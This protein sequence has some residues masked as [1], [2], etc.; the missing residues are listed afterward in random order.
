[1][2]LRLRKQEVRRVFLAFLIA[3]VLA[4][5][6]VLQAYSR[7]G[8]QTDPFPWPKLFAWELTGWYL[9]LIFLIPIQMLARR[10]PAGAVSWKLLAAIHLPL[11]FLFSIF[12]LLIQMTIS[13]KIESQNSLIHDLLNE[14]W[15][16]IYYLS[17]RMLIYMGILVVCHAVEYRTRFGNEELKSSRLESLLKQTKLEKIKKQLNPQFLYETLDFIVKLIHENSAR[18]ERAIARL[19]TFLRFSLQNSGALVVP[20]KQELEFVKTYLDLENSVKERNLSLKIGCASPLNERLVPVLILFH[21][22]QIFIDCFSSVGNPKSHD[23]SIQ[24]HAKHADEKLHFEISFLPDSSA[25]SPDAYHRVFKTIGTTLQEFYDMKAT[26]DFQSGCVMLTFSV[27]CDEAE[28][29]RIQEKDVESCF[30]YF[31]LK[32]QPKKKATSSVWNWAWIPVFWTL[33]G[34]YFAG[35]E[36]HNL[37]NP[38]SWTNQMIQAIPWACWA[39]V[40]PLILRTAQRYPVERKWLLQSLVV[41][42]S[43]NSAIWFTISAIGLFATWI[44]APTGSYSEYLFQNISKSRFAFSFFVYWIM[45]AAGAAIDHYRRYRSEELNTIR[46]QSGLFQAQIDVLRMQLH[47]HFLFNAL[48]SISQLLHENVKAAEEMLLRLKEFLKLTLENTSIH[49]TTL[50]DELEYMKCYLEIQHMRF[51]DKLH[52][53]MNI[54]PQTMNNLVPH[55]LWQ[56]VIENAIRHGISRMNGPGVIE[57]VCKRN[58]DRLLLEV[59][60]NGPGLPQMPAVRQG[61]GLT[62]I[63][64]ILDS[65]YGS[66]H[67]FTIHNAP[68]GGMIASLLIPAIAPPEHEL[69]AQSKS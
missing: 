26:S 67:E 21:P 4:F 14:H 53:K 51:Q 52:V 8:A 41:H 28:S 22:V 5:V 65:L 6:F 25:L 36:A 68:E 69:I 54:E 60:D 66:S 9:W 56:P 12:H 18:A 62:T 37:A 10:F 39:A 15:F 3:T 1:M 57:I 31:E 42:F 46:L 40:T 55:L 16:C 20:L 44:T 59:R 35:R 43:L 47:P 64:A 17:W 49:E 29:Q 13:W 7:F 45:V 24:I 30:R 38:S 61:V 19:G 58:E 2:N 33:M 27:R 48:N 50:K 11:S 32:E 23:L 63:R 34:F